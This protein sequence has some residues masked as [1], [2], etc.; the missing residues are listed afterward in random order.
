MRTC[1]TVIASIV[2]LSHL[3]V[4]AA[5]QPTTRTLEP[6]PGVEPPRS[7]HRGRLERATL[8]PAAERLPGDA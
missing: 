2:P 5:L 3:T 1:P 4:P 8:D 6:I 7:K